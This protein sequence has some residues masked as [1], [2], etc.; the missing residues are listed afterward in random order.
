MREKSCGAVV[1]CGDG[2]RGEVLLIQSKRGKHWGFPKGHMELNE[3]ERQTAVREIAEETGVAVKI[4]T[5]FRTTVS[6]R[7]REGNF[8]EV[9][10]FLCF[11]EKQEFVMQTEEI[12][13]AAWIPMEQALG[14]LTF[15]NDRRVMRQAMDYLKE[16]E[17]RKEQKTDAG[18]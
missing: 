12:R 17:Q 1:I 9:V 6:Y 4:N 13:D 10:Y 8:K 5:N 7:L 14:K 16:W 3:T 15:R 18:L 2:L 11:V